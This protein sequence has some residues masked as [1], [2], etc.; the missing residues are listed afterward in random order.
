MSRLLKPTDST[1][2]GAHSSVV[3]IEAATGTSEDSS[4]LNERVSVTLLAW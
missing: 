4:P 3:Y 2:H 1:P